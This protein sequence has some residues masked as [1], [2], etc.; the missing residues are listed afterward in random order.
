MKN[1]CKY[2]MIVF[3]GL[4]LFGLVGCGKKDKNG[5][6]IS[7][8]HRHRDRVNG[9]SHSTPFKSPR[10]FD[11]EYYPGRIVGS[12]QDNFQYG[13][14]N[15]VSSFM[16]P[17]DP[18]KGISFVSGSE[19]DKTGVWFNGHI[20]VR[21]GFNE[22]ETHNS[23]I[24]S[25]S[26]IN[27]LIWDKYAGQESGDG[28]IPGIKIGPAKLV[29]GDI[30]GRSVELK[31]AYQDKDGDTLGYL[32]LEGTYNSRAFSGQFYFDNKKF[33]NPE[34]YR[35]HQGCHGNGACGQMGGFYISTCKIFDCDH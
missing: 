10:D 5:G 4:S 21:D 7:N 17:L 6:R 26:F 8:G 32:S 3:L 29:S 30:R 14:D 13:V 2:M 33:A 19:D 34:K 11:E 15:L 16:D 20:K 23:V 35:A 12:P 31:F 18:E 9:D 1:L 25:G 28:I 24:Q 27:V 22:R